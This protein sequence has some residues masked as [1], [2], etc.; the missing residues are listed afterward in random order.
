[1]ICDFYTNNQ[2]D[3]K[4]RNFYISRHAILKALNRED[5]DINDLDIVNHSYLKR[6]PSILVSLSH[7][8]D[9]AVALIHDNN[10]EKTKLKSI[11][12]DFELSNRE[13][14]ADV[15]KYIGHIKDSEY[16]PLELWVIK[17]ACFKA[18]SPIY[19]TELMKEIWINNGEFGLK[20]SKIGDFEYSLVNK[21]NQTFLIAKAWF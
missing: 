16:S 3:K 6:F 12:V 9:Y 15:L 13:V 5:L 18:L 1:M 7:T 19:G 17:E 4:Q 10:S 11:G 14:K 21:F 8:K 2:V 20:E